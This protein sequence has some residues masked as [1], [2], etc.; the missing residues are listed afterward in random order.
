VIGDWWGQAPRRLQVSPERTQRW[1]GL[2]ATG[3]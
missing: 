2:G 1:I 3:A